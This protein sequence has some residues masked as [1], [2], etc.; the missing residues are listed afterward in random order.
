MEVLVVAVVEA[1]AAVVV[2]GTGHC[3]QAAA[4]AA[5]GERRVGN[6]QHS[7]DSGRSPVVVVAACE[8]FSLAEESSWAEQT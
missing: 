2:A 8:H 4:A 5:A 3:I 1:L 6:E 7:F